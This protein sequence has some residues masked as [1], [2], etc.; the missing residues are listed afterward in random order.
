MEGQK[1]RK[2][3]S[4]EDDPRRRK[5]QGRKIGSLRMDRGR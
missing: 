5:S 1:T 4:D 2:K 3:R